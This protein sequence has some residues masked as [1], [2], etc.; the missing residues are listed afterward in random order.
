MYYEG[1]LILTLVHQ[2]PFSYVC[3][4][5]H[6]DALARVARRPEGGSRAAFGARDAAG[7]AA[8][9]GARAGGRRRAARAEAARGSA[10]LAGTRVHRTVL[11]R[12]I[13]P[14]LRSFCATLRVRECV[15]VVRARR[16]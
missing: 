14:A 9:L 6:A 8:R 4:A 12:T 15:C 3:D 5:K 2:K 7:E 1:S 11:T 10:R 16:E 13:G